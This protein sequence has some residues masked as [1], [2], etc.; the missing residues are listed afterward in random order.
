MREALAAQMDREME[1]LLQRSTSD[2]EN[3]RLKQAIYYLMRKR[4]N[5][6]KVNSD[7]KKTGNKTKRSIISN[8]RRRTRLAARGK[9]LSLAAASD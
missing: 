7:N 5:V 8:T 9:R 1:Q 2:P 6:L 4:S 3:K